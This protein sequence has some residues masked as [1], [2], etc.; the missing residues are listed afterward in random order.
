MSALPRE[1]KTD[2]VHYEKLCGFTFS[3]DNLAAPQGLRP[4]PLQIAQ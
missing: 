4:T 2:N 3:N 1:L